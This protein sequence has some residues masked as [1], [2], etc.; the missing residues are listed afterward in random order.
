MTKLDKPLWLSPGCLEYSSPRGSGLPSLSNIFLDNDYAEDHDPITVLSNSKEPPFFSGV[1][2]SRFAYSQYATNSAYLCNSLMFFASL[3]RLGSKASRLLMFPN[4]MKPD[5][6]GTSD[7]RLLLKAQNEYGVKLVPIAV[8]HRSGG[9]SFNQTQYDRVLALDS[10]STL[11]QHMDELFLLPPAPVA[12]PRAYW[13]KG[14]S[15]TLTTALIL[16]QPSTAEFARVAS[17]IATANGGVFDMEI[18][19]T[20]YGRDCMVLPHRRYVLL[21][22]EFRIVD[23]NGTGKGH[24]AYLGNEYETWDA[25]KALREAKFLHFS[26][27][28]MPKPW[29]DAPDVTMQDV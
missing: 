14:A 20:L 7:S 22:G 19:N 16:L 8:Q 12:L 1:D 6:N 15:P 9:D 21:T 18:V 5:P 10:D 25:D 24:A 23:A 3:E 17:A 28:P 27:W 2:W 13:L 29:L 11:L 4:S 26:D